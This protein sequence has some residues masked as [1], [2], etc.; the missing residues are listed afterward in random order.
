MHHCV[1][2]LLARRGGLALAFFLPLA[3]RAQGLEPIG[4]NP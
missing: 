2:A 4:V 3:A 1:F